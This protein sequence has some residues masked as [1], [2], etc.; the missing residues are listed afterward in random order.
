[1]VYKV[2]WQEESLEDLLELPKKT[3][4]QIVTKVETYLAQSPD[5]LGKPLSGRFSG[6]YRYR[7]GDYRIIYEI[8]KKELHI[9]IVP[10][11]H[12]KDVYD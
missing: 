2:L 8:V 6:L 10:V 9:Y 12:R 3:A 11:G 1:M 4:S 5:K 7:F